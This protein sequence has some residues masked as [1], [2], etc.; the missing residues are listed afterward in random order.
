MSAMHVLVVDDEAA[1]RHVMRDILHSCGALVYLAADAK[2][3]EEILSTSPIDV[4]FVD[5]CLPGDSGFRIVQQATATRPRVETVILTGYPS[6]ESTVNALRHGACD[7]VAKPIT[8][9][10][11]RAALERARSGVAAGADPPNL[12]TKSRPSQK[13][14]PQLPMVAASPA[15]RRI[16]TAAKRA[17]K[18][19]APIVIHG[20]RGVGKATL[21]RMIHQYRD[22]GNHAMVYLACNSIREEQLDIL[23][24]PAGAGLPGQAAP[25]GDSLVNLISGTTLFLDDIGALPMW[26]QSRLLDIL[27]GSKTESASPN[28]N[29]TPDV[30]VI[31]TVSGDLESAVAKNEFNR[32]L[33]YYL[34]VASIWVPPLRQRPEDIGALAE[35]FLSQMAKKDC[36]ENN[37]RLRAFST[38]AQE[39]LLRYNWPGNIPELVN[40]I[41]RAVIL[42]EE[43]EIDHA[44]VEKL[45]NNGHFRQNNTETIL[46]PMLGNLKE[47]ERH[48]VREVIQRCAGNKAAAARTL[49]LHRK[50][51]YRLLEGDSS[52]AMNS[53]GHPVPA[54]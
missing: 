25:R 40:V 23:L 35:S 30:R 22:R 39:V 37:S 51:I 31:A 41:E 34:N 11:I 46:V 4:L 12:M 49:G 5:V 20:E 53:M 15:M 10:K 44:T 28:G 47:I 42:A 52:S 43:K 8:R 2:E 7:Y 32:D 36:P 24:T 13:T 29:R 38:E 27:N 50:T 33:Y 6:V 17:A 1:I 3:A 26:A 48:I 54:E 45:T 9:E 14:D 16:I 18:M 19:D 21:A